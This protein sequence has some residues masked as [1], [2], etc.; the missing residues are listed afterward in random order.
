MVASLRCRALAVAVCCCFLTEAT[1]A[2][3]SGNEL[4]SL[5]RQNDAEAFCSGY[6]IG[7][8]EAFDALS[9]A[10]KLKVPWCFSAGVVNSQI[11]DVVKLYLRDHPETRHYTGPTLVMLALEEKFPCN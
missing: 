1:K 2:Y 3:E 4:W 5:C 11:I 10:K 9:A 6:I 8:L 7:V